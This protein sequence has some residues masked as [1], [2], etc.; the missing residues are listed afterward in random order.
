MP[1]NVQGIYITAAISSVIAFLLFGFAIRNLR[2]PANKQLLWLAFIIALPLQPLAFYCV[3]RNVEPA[4]LARLAGRQ[5][6]D[7]ELPLARSLVA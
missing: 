6:R 4:S 7:Y 2:L 1:I 5:L 3:I